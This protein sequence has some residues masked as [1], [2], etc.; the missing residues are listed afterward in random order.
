MSTFDSGYN[1]LFYLGFDFQLLYVLL[2]LKYLS[3]LFYDIMFKRLLSVILVL[4]INF[5]YLG[6]SRRLLF[7]DLSII[8]GV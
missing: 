2:C 7:N 4:E 1:Y 5:L 8:F 3:S 6:S